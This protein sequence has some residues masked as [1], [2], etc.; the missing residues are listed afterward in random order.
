[1]LRIQK[2]SRPDQWRYVPTHQ[3]PADHATQSVCAGHLKNTN[4]LSGTEFLS[5][6][7]PGTSES[8]CDLVDLSTDPDI[9]RLVSAFSTAA[10]S[11]QLGS[12][13]FAKF[14]TWKPLTRAVTHLIHIARH[15]KTTPE[16]KSSCK[17][18]HYCKAEFTVE[19]CS[20][21][22]AV[23]IQAVQQEV[24]S[25][26]IKCIQKQ[27]KMPKTSPLRNLDIFVDSEGLL[28]VRGRLQHSSHPN[29]Q[30]GHVVL[31]RNSQAQRNEWPLGL[32]MQ[33]FPSKD[34]RVRQ[35]EV[36]I[37]KPEGT[38]IFLRPIN[39]F[40]LLLSPDKSKW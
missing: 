21:A 28:R 13:R 27:E 16:E 5:R 3:N 1:M 2:S 39:E 8:T 25:Q 36:K 37:I 14:S 32:V 7:E 9:R 31:L 12:Q 34:E 4:W 20:K 22:S 11:E 10:S 30:P 24:Y 18:W 26:E 38:S 6:P 15:F 23:I 35:V 29:I 19:E 17:G 40:V 33:T